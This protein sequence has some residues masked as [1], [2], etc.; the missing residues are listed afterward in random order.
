MPYE[1]CLKNRPNNET[2]TNMLTL[3]NLAKK[4]RT[5]LEK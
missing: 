5:A 1:R 4:R 2:M 3:T